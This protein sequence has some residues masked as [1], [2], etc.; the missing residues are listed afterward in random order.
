M[1][2]KIQIRFLFQEELE[3]IS[4]LFDS[5]QRRLAVNKT[6]H[7]ACIFLKLL[8]L[9]CSIQTGIFERDST[10]SMRLWMP[11][12]CE[13]RSYVQV[14]KFFCRMRSLGEEVLHVKRDP[15]FSRD[16]E[17]LPEGAMVTKHHSPI[18]S[19]RHTWASPTLSESI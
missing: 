2:D 14:Y 13:V 17:P 9:P 16:K 6:M 4:I 8:N 5:V 7:L 10:A 19:P 11:N 3:T 15:A 1:A 18:K 12:G